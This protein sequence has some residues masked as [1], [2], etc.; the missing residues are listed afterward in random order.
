M[1]LIT[2]FDLGWNTS[3]EELHLLKCSMQVVISS[4][5]SADRL[6]VVAFFGCSNRDTKFEGQ[7]AASTCIRDSPLR[8]TRLSGPYSNVGF[9]GKLLVLIL[10][11]D[12]EAWRYLQEVTPRSSPKD[13][14]LCQMIEHVVGGFIADYRN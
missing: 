10:K 5:N 8:D 2:V 12:P 13:Q 14:S 6:S 7:L 9:G 11:L 3:T 4:L 1:D